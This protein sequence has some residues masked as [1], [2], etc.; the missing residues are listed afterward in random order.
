[1]EW[2]KDACDALEALK[3]KYNRYT[4][5]GTALVF[6]IE[7]RVR[8]A[9]GREVHAT[10]VHEYGESYAA[11]MRPWRVGEYPTNAR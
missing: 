6:M 2:T 5:A 7:N 11:N 1:M 8:E 10:D 9:G 3:A 4:E